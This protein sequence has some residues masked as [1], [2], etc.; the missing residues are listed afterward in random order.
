MTYACNIVSI[1]LWEYNININ[2]HRNCKTP[3]AP[4]ISLIIFIF[5]AFAAPTFA[6]AS[7]IVSLIKCLFPDNRLLLMDNENPETTPQNSP[8]RDLVLKFVDSVN[9]GCGIFS[10]IFVFF[11]GS[12]V[13]FKREMIIQFFSFFEISNLAIFLDDIVKKY[14]ITA[15]ITI[16]IL[17]ITAVYLYLRFFSNVQHNEFSDDMAKYLQF[18]ETLFST[19]ADLTIIGILFLYL[20]IV[21]QSYGEFIITLFVIGGFSLSIWIISGPYTKIIKDYSAIDTMNQHLNTLHTKSAKELFSGINSISDIICY[22]FLRKNSVWITMTLFL[23]IVLAIFGIGE[24][25]NVLTIIL[26]ELMVI[27]YALFQSQIGSFPRIPVNIYL[28]AGE[29]YNRI[30][31]IRENREI[32]VILTQY[33]TLFLLMKPHIKM[34][35]PIIELDASQ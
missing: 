30:Y 15:L 5:S 29:I 19:L 16:L 20:V 34:V 33:D 10:I 28:I 8:E 1:G 25:Y 9:S 12:L 14:E 32:I 21:K 31:L 26:L 24:N 18:Y 23:T 2:C 22:G 35:E 13:L 7:A 17:V 27:R 3:S 4:S 11:A 6:R